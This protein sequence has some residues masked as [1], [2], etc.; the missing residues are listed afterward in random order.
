VT[1]I[2][3]ALTIAGS[4][5]GGGA[6]IQA[7]IKAMSANGVY[8]ASVITALTAQNTLGVT[9]IHDVPADFIAA[10][11]D[12]VFKDIKFGA[13]KIGMLSRV[14]TIR[15]VA[16]GLRR[17]RARNVVV[18]PVMVAASGDPLLRDDAVEALKS[19]LFP[20]ATLVTPNL[21]E[22]ARLTG[23]PVA[24]S[25]DEMRAQAKQIAGQTK[26]AV[27]VKGGHGSGDESEDLLWRA[28]REQW[29]A[30]PRIATKNTHGT[31]CSLSSAIAAHLARGASLPD[32]V[33]RAK[34]WLTGAIGAADELSVG[35]GRG[36]V[37]HFHELWPHE[38]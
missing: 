19:E 24:D 23:L 32:A 22:A 36:P 37:H 30:A 12:A 25:R 6:G 28:G 35:K 5:S 31:G 34:H 21:H 18:D 2:A 14:E 7:D 4:D 17:Y 29:F 26:L 1:A 16:D 33:K 27:L 15:A 8:A 9:V 10:Q 38:S 20:L 13:V 11:T 3:N